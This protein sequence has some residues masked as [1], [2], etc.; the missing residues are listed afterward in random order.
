MN[1]PYNLIT[2]EKRD[3]EGDTT[4]KMIHYTF[5]FQTFCLMN[6]FNLF[7]SR[8]LGSKTSK[9]WNIFT[10]VCDN[11]WFLIIFFAELNA[12]YAIVSYGATRTIFGCETMTLHMHIVSSCPGF[13]TMI[14]SALAKLIPYS[15]C[16]KL[17]GLPEGNV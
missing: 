11:W 17:P 8:V 10:K 1:I 9:Q 16:E 13:G 14:V 4:N 6:M 15:F 3:L 12:Q 5:M 7:N 2:D